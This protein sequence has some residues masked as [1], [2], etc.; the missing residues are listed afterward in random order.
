MAISE[1]VQSRGFLHSLWWNLHGLHGATV[2]DDAVAHLLTQHGGKRL[3]VPTVAELV[4]RNKKR[5]ADYCPK[6]E[7][8]P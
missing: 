3:Q 6:Y 4:G 1:A 8:L 5:I 2:A 7:D